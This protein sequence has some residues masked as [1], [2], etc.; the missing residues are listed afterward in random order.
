[1]GLGLLLRTSIGRDATGCITWIASW[2]YKHILH[3]KMEVLCRF[4]VLITSFIIICSFISNIIWINHQLRPYN[5][6][7]SPW[8]LNDPLENH[9]IV[10]KPDGA[11]LILTFQPYPAPLVHSALSFLPTNEP[12]YSNIHTVNPEEI[13]QCFTRACFAHVKW[14]SYILAMSQP[15]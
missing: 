1:M 13:D 4:E 12:E 5:N 10:A 9:N 3:G 8:E 6:L 2:Y 15:A 7:Y 11:I 14:C